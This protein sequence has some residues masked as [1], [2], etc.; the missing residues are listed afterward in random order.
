MGKKIVFL[1][2]VPNV[3]IESLILEPIRAEAAEPISETEGQK[4]SRSPKGDFMMKDVPT[5]E[6]VQGINPEED[7]ATR[8][9][10]S[11]HSCTTVTNLK[12]SSL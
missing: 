12:I 9:S 4:T 7:A 1:C 8:N 11:P 2:S 6:H 10:P 5:E 3:S